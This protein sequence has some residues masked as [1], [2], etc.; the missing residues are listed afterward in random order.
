ME[1]CIN[2]YYMKIPSMHK[3]ELMTSCNRTVIKNLSTYICQA[4]HLRNSLIVT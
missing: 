3:F 4:F 2:S 1:N